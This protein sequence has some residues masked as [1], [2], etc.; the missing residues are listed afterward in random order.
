M[1]PPWPGM[2][3][4]TQPGFPEPSDEPIRRSFSLQGEGSCLRVEWEVWVEGKTTWLLYPTLTLWCV[5]LH[6][7][8]SLPQ[9][10]FGKEDL[11]QIVCGSRQPTHRLHL[12]LIS[13]KPCPMWLKCCLLSQWQLLHQDG[14]FAHPRKPS[15]SKCRQILLLSLFS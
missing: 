7:H 14:T 12:E 13:Q 15:W 9:Q 11:T 1:K 5:Q 3:P 4:G 10:L 6:P 2:P 8:D